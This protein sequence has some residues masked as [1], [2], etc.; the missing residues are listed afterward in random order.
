VTPSVWQFVVPIP[1]P[2]RDVNMYAL[3]A[4]DG[5]TL[6]DA[7][8]D[9]AQAREVFFAGLSKA[10][11]DIDHLRTIV[12]SHYHPDHIG[13]AKELQQQSGAQVY[14]HRLD[15]TALWAMMEHPAE[16]QNA[17]QE[18]ATFFASHGVPPREQRLGVENENR[19]SALR[20]RTPFTLSLPPRETIQ[21]VEDGE[22]IE[23]SHERYQIF[24]VPGHSDGLISLWRKRDGLF[25]STDHVLP[26]ITPN[27]GIFT[28]RGRRPNPL[29]DYLVSL[30]KVKDLSASMVLPG[31]RQPF[32][33]LADRVAEIESHHARRLQLIT[34]LLKDHPQHAYSVTQ[35]LFAQRL[36]S[37]D[38][39]RMATAETLAH[40]EYLRLAGEIQTIQENDLLLY[41]L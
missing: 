8:M 6:V 20:Q 15:A 32:E 3:V 4:E 2:L 12:L 13:L 26:R 37:E 19:G 25:L 18:T 39:L 5:W 1:F 9:T 36:T 16:Q 7:G 30:R 10:S 38:A 31:H 33:N 34:D 40:L 11:L 17:R 24:W 21:F 35:Q 28:P 41:S 14:M 29:Q 27:I 23:L 22:E